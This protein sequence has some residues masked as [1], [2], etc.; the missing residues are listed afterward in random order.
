[1][2]C[3][4]C[5][6]SA[7]T[8]SPCPATGKKCNGCHGIGHFQGMCPKSRKPGTNGT[9]GQLRLQQAKRQPHRLVPVETTLNTETHATVPDCVP[10]SGSDVD[11]MGTRQLKHIGGLVE[12][13]CPVTDIV[14]SVNGER[15]K[16]VRKIAA[17][18][19]A[20][21]ISH[22]TTIHVYDDL[23]DALLSRTSLAA[24]GFLP[25]NWPKQM[26]RVAALQS[27]QPAMPTPDEIQTSGMGYCT[28]LQMY[29]PTPHYVPCLARLW[30]S[31]WRLTRSLAM[32]LG[33]APSPTRIATRYSSNWKTWSP[34]A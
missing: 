11:A 5:G 34:G 8:K 32:L 6:R 33:H 22:T 3:N 7:H 2:K 10:D 1:M 19:S 30:T 27:D 9:I 13:I 28:S 24:L 12:N 4:N 18:L 16:S 23:S 29:S 26:P 31:S 25:E 14:T 17:T 21:S 20:G 15:L